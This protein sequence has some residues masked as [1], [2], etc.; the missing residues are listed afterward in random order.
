MFDNSIVNN[1]IVTLSGKRILNYNFSNNWDHVISLI[2]KT[3]DYYLTIVCLQLRCLFF[4]TEITFNGYQFQQ[5]QIR[6]A[7]GTINL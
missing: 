2:Y 1:K 6:N 3:F 5:K 4:L 7:R